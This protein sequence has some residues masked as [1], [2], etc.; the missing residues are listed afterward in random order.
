MKPV[1]STTSTTFS[2]PAAAQEVGLSRPT[3]EAW[4]KSG[5]IVPTGQHNKKLAFSLA[6]IEKLRAIKEKR[7]Q[8]REVL[9]LNPTLKSS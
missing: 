3:L 5:V 8:A 6:D 2:V 1:P 4:V 9:S 7:D